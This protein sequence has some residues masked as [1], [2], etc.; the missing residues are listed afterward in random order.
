MWPA[1]KYNFTVDSSIKR[2][3]QK[4]MVFENHRKRLSLSVTRHVIFDRTKIGEKYQNTK[5]EMR[6]FSNT[7]FRYVPEFVQVRKAHEHN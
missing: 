7:M 6:H 3:F 4:F 2:I 1:I 5:I